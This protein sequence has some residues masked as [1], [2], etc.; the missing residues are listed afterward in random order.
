MQI[1]NTAAKSFQTI[2]NQAIS[3]K[4]ASGEKVP[5]KLLALLQQM[6]R[7]STTTDQPLRGAQ[8]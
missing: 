5:R 1:E 3:Q 4:I 2:I 6:P 8:P 7:L